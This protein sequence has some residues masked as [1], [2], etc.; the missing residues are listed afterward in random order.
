M[1]SS[2]ASQAWPVR[3]EELLLG[4]FQ[5]SSEAIVVA[6]ANGRILMFSPG[7]EAAFGYTAEEIIG[8]PV[9]R[10][11]PEASRQ[12]HVG[13]REAFANGQSASRLMRE[14]GVLLALRKN[15]E[16]F[17]IEASLSRQVTAN[18][19]ILIAILRDVSARWAAEQAINQSEQ[20][21]KIA[22]QIAE[23]H[24]FEI[25]FRAKTLMKTGA[26][27]TF[28]D[29]PM[30]FKRVAKNIWGGIRPDHRAAARAAWRHC[31]KTREPFSID[32]P[33]HRRD[34]QVVWARLSAELIK[35][36]E[37]RPLRLIGA[38]RNIT[39]ARLQEAA[40]AEAVAA[41]QAANTAKST[42]LTTMSHEIRTPLN[43]VLGMAQAMLQDDLAPV[44]RERLNVIRQSGES[45]LAILNDVLDL[46]KIEAGKLA[47]DVAAFDLGELVR[48]AQA[49]FTALANKKGLSFSLDIER[50][51]GMYVGDPTRLRQILY[52]LISN[53]L[54][55]TQT[56]EVRVTADYADGALRLD[57]ADTGIGM[58]PRALNNL[59]RPFV[60]ADTSTTRRY[61][62]SGLGLAISWRLAELM[63]GSLTATSVAGEGSTF[64]AILPLHRLEQ[65]PDPMVDASSMEAPA[66][67][68]LP[69]ILDAGSIRI[70]AAEDNVTN[71]LVLKTVLHQAGIEPLVVA[72]GL[73]VVQAWRDNP[74][75]IILMD[76]QMPELDGVAAARLIR[77]EEAATGRPRTPILALTANALAHQ[78]AEY[79]AAGMDTAVTKPID[80]RALFEAI[81]A[82]LS[83]DTRED[84][85]VARLETSPS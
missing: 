6:D 67:L 23:L 1:T 12:A 26:E 58:S 30:T 76:I 55:F 48:G 16:R 44:Q 9:E 18:G 53:A 43:G 33:T 38:L 50:A 20:R 47:L 34:G 71:Q 28:F 64:T 32:V 35:D 8:E 45:L 10:L 85:E 29:R 59:F 70:L 31:Q 80:V 75:D 13:Y 24:V 37:G 2:S 15:G 73:E 14:R 83:P 63:G 77:D 19:L 7:A 5:I 4:I 40:M 21:L 81:D 41:A 49:T 62:G 84:G 79:R 65:L 52:N 25:D 39:E 82:A 68:T 3:H 27:D 56:G 69:T 57:V 46:S 60:Q 51:A 74:V 61:G 66:Q 42:F 11:L 36:N 78:I 54:K 72:N 22:V 17:A